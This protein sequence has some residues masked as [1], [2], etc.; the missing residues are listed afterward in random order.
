MLLWSWIVI[1]EKTRSFCLSTSHYSFGAACRVRIPSTFKEHNQTN[2]RKKNVRINGV[3]NDM[4]GGGK[5][6]IK[7]E[8]KINKKEK[9]KG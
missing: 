7:E 1:R 8:R 2:G 6:V 5:P 3:D 4:A 9:K